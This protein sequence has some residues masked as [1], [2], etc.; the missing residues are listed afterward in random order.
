MPTSGNILG[1]DI[2]D[3]NT[4]AALVVK[5]KVVSAAQQERFNREKRTR[6]FPV[7]AVLFCLKKAGLTIADLDAV[8]L[9]VNPAIYLENLQPAQSESIRFRGELLAAPVN[10]L[11]GALGAMPGQ[12]Q[13]RTGDVTVHY[14]THHDAHAA[15]AFYLSGFDSAAV[16]TWDA[17]GE[18]ESTVMFSGK[19]TKIN[20]I[21]NV[22]FPHSLGSFYSAITEFLG[23]RP[24]FD[25]WKVMAAAAHGNPESYLSVMQNLICATDSGGIEVNLPFFN[26]YQFHRPGSFTEKLV[27]LLGESYAKESRR[28]KRFLDIAAAAQRVCEQVAFALLNH[29]SSKVKSPNLCLAG[30]FAYNCVLNGKIQDNTPFRNVFVPPMPDDSGTSAGAALAVAHRQ[31]GAMRTKA[32]TDNYFGPGFT[33]AQIKAELQKAKIRFSRIADPSVQAA[34]LIAQGKLV[35]WFQGRMEF[36]DRALGNRSILA[37]PRNPKIPGRLNR[38]VK[39]REPFLPF[40]PAVLAQKARDWFVGT[41]PTPFMEKAVKVRPEVAAAIPAVLGPDHSARVQTVTRKQNPRFFELIQAFDQLT[42]VPMVL[43]TSFNLT[44]EPIVCSPRDALRTFFC[45]GLDA[46]VI[47]SFLVRK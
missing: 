31:K 32:L 42:G 23:F 39:E 24:L 3:Y 47:G 2:N 37:D 43:N 8:A 19:G 21:Q 40:A 15:C 35:G 10:Y 20:R 41:L 18:K 1:L 33:D 44:G 38:T 12:T 7:Q 45:C 36:G 17:F 13:L 11:L 28:D 34:K 27:G 30:G 29:L 14:I 46:L 4:S 25:E 22:E 16:C 26:Y 9:S 6:R 5:G